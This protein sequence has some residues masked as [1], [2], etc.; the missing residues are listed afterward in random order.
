MMQTDDRVAGGPAR[1]RR[2]RAGVAARTAIGL[3]FGT[4]NSSVALAAEVPGEASTVELAKYP[5]MGGLTAS[6]RS[7]L[8]FEQLG[9]S[10]VRI[11]L[12]SGPHCWTGPEAI[13]RYLAH[14]ERGETDVRGRLIQSLKSYLPSRSLLGTEIFGQR[15]L[16]EDLVSRMLRD[17]RLGAERQF[18]RPIEHAVVGRPVRFAGG[19]TEEDAAFALERMRR[20]LEL[21]G[22]SRVEFEYEPVA[23][24]YAYGAGLEKQELLLIGDFGGG[25][26]DFSLVRMG[27]GE[28]TVVGTSGVGVAGDAFDAKLVR[29]LVSP[30]LGAESLAR[31]M[32]KLLPAVPTW[33]YANL[34]RWHYLS[35]L[36]TRNV[37]EIL[38]S[39]RV[40][41]LEPDKIE[42]LL[43]LIEEDLGYQLH[44]AVQRVKYELSQQEMGRFLFDDGSMELDV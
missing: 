21:A 27:R 4:T 2:P 43:T 18:G 9:R 6:F 17:L 3:D 38:R 42:A 41:A 35:F 39:A 13:E 25:T 10:A 11:G 31:S 36:R 15:Y 29:R 12:P 8:Y 26:S 30:A 32:G 23:A 44:Q 40:R 37:L 19:V 7:L 28:R 22:F 14:A 5:A 1:P 20:S 16:L 24:A 33:I 34:E